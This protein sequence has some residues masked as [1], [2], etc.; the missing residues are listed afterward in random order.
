MYTNE[1]GVPQDHVQAYLWLDLSV[2]KGFD[3]ALRNRDIVAKRM[4][5]TRSLRPSA[6][7]ASG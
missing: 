5:P 2:A 4:I 3:K 6:S 7:P 1:H